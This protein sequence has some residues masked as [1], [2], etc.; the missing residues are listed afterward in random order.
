MNEHDDGIA[1]EL[2]EAQR[3]ERNAQNERKLKVMERLRGYWAEENWQYEVSEFLYHNEIRS[4]DERAAFWRTFE[5]DPYTEH[6]VHLYNDEYHAYVDYAKDLRVRWRTYANSREEE[7]RQEAARKVWAFSLTT[8]DRD[9]APDLW[10]ATVKLFEQRSVP[11]AVGEAHLEYGAS[12]LPHVHGWYE[13]DHG[14]RVFAKVFKRCWPLWGE[15]KRHHTAFRGGFHE[16]AKDPAAYRLYAS[17]E[18]RLIVRKEKSNAILYG[19]KP[20]S[21]RSSCVTSPPSSGE[22][23]EANPTLP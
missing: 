14:G 8:P 10:E 18:Q 15:D 11:I 7:T 4:A 3:L 19:P 12:G 1:T 5:L 6:S 13:T 17:A 22:A 9:A 16:K 21:P 2:G 20:S 23:A